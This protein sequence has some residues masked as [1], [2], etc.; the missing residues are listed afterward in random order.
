MPASSSASGRWWSNPN[1]NPVTLLFTRTS[2]LPIYH[3]YAG[4]GARGFV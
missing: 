4:F 1:S 2:G 3:T